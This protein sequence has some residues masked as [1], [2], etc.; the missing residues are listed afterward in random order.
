MLAHGPA[1]SGEPLQAPGKQPRLHPHQHLAAASIRLYN[2]RWIHAQFFLPNT[3]KSGCEEA[4]FARTSW[5]TIRV[6]A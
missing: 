4:R 6:Y 3:P 5:C 1:D 2:I